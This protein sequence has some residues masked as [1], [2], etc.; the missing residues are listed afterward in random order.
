MLRP[1]RE[2]L[3]V[4]DLPLKMPGGVQ[5]GTRITGAYGHFGPSRLARSFT[6]ERRR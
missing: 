2:N 5:I 4:I 3:W 6:K 1:L